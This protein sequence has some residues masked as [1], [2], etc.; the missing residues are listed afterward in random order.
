[1]DALLDTPLPLSEFLMPPALP[2][3]DLHRAVFELLQGRADA[4]VYGAQ[5]VNAYVGQARMTSDVDVLSTRPRDLAEAVRE[6][7]HARFHAAFRV[8]KA[9]DTWRVYQVGP[10]RRPLVDVH[11]VLALPRAVTRHGI[12]VAAPPELVAY[13]VVAADA[14]RGA[15]KGHQDMADLGRLLA[16]FPRLR[17]TGTVEFLLEAHGARPT[18]LAL[19]ASLQGEGRVRRSPARRPG[20]GG[21]R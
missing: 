15:P 14:R 4:V 11:Q 21:A 20:R 12:R 2:L 10:P 19:W 5:A 13:K 9:R 18:A 1:V 3:R 17:T 6:A 7:L 16:R 8:R